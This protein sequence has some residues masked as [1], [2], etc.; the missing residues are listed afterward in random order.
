VYSSASMPPIWSIAPGR[1]GHHPAYSQ[2]LP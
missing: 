1:D 2:Y